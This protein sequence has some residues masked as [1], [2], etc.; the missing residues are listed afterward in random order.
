VEDNIVFRFVHDYLIHIKGGFPFGKGELNAYNLHAKLLPKEAI[1]AIFTEV[2][3]QA[4]VYMT[5]GN[6]PEQKIAVLHGFDFEK[7]GYYNGELIDG[8]DDMRSTTL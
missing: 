4:A 5:Y 6:F 8:G 7:V 1:P 3:G 2:V